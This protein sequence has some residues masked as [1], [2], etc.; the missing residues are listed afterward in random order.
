V[1]PKASTLPDEQRDHQQP[2]QIKFPGAVR[3]M[4]KSSA[5]PLWTIAREHGSAT[6]PF[7]R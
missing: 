7:A 5:A 2:S 4:K 6:Q 1:T 3:P